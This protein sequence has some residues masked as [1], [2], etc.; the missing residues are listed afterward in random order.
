MQQH[1]DAKQRCSFQR[2]A[3]HY[4]H[5]RVLPLKRSCTLLPADWVSMETAKSFQRNAA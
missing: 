4:V 2:R 5:M 1:L 3:A